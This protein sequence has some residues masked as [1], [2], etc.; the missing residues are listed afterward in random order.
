MLEDL[1]AIELWNRNE[2]QKVQVHPSARLTQAANL[3]DVG[4]SK[5]RGQVKLCQFSP[6]KSM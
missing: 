5:V 2:G 4:I 3:T 1:R 6:C